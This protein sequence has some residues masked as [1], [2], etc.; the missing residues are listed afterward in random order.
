LK[1][2]EDSAVSNDF[3]FIVASY[4]VHSAKGCHFRG[5]K[6]FGR[7]YP[8]KRAAKALYFPTISLTG[9]LDE[10]NGTGLTADLMIDYGANIEALPIIEI[11]LEGDPNAIQT[12]D[13]KMQRPRRKICP[14]DLPEQTAE[15]MRSLARGAFN[16]LGLFDFARVDFRM[17][18]QGG[19]H[20]LEINSMASLNPTGS[21][22]YAG[23]VAGMDFNTLVNR[24]LETAVLRYFGKTFIETEE[25]QKEE[26][27][28]GE[29]L[30]VRIRSYLRSHLSTIV[31]YTEKMVSINS[32]VHNI[33]GVNTLGNWI[34]G[35]FQQ[36][37][38]SRHLYPQTEIGNSLYFTNHSKTENDILLVGHLDTPYDYRS[39]TPFKEDRGKLYGSGI[40]SCKGGIAVIL[41]ALQALRFARV[42]RRLHCGVLLTSDNTLH[43]RYTHANNSELMK[44]S[45]RVIG[46][47]HGGLNGGLALS[48]AGI[49]Q[50]YIELSNSKLTKNNRKTDL[51]TVLAEKVI[52]WHK[53]AAKINGIFVQIKTLN[54]DSFP[55][56]KAEFANATINVF[57]TKKNLSETIKD[58]IK[59][60]VE[61]RSNGN[62][63]VRFRLTG[64]R[65]PVENTTHNRKFFNEVNKIAAKIEVRV[66]PI[67]QDFPSDIAHTPTH[68]PLLEGF[69]PLGGET[70]SP[71]E[72]IIRDSLI[73][74]SA[75]LALVLNDSVK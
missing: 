46:T 42:L 57:Y 26:V 3:I 6:S 66:E 56:Q 8:A 28:S 41:A 4:G 37:G 24:M 11:D 36:L 34:S 10:L 48:C 20:L 39:F 14:A 62:L 27:K 52:A 69:G 55:G 58:Q 47:N 29:Q 74:R 70:D 44:K 40:A 63:Q 73:D 64:G 61:K 30:P 75:L 32:Y 38:F 15:A 7:S 45:K 5:D 43:N 12:V 60:I 13:D 23:S 51:A 67:H 1:R 22:V 71:S 59:E 25:K 31:D 16:A 50:F 54:L 9:A 17:D 19:L 33:E 68:I 65:Q 21:F 53:I 72:F 49:H 35:R 18:Q 2:T